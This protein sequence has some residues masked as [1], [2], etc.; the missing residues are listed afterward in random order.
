MLCSVGH[1][2]LFLAVHGEERVQVGVVGLVALHCIQCLLYNL[3][4]ARVLAMAEQALYG[5]GKG[6]VQ[7]LGEGGPWVVRQD[8]D[9]HNSI[10]LDMGAAVVLLG[11]EGAYLSRG[12]GSCVGAGDGRLDDGGE[13]KHLFALAAVSRASVMGIQHGPT[14]L[15]AA[16]SQK[17]LCCVSACVKM[18]WSKATYHSPGGIGLWRVGIWIAIPMGRLC[19]RPLAHQAAQVEALLELH[20]CQPSQ[21]S[22]SL[23]VAQTSSAGFL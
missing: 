13:M 17:S 8:S 15:A 20:G 5:I 23:L 3:R 6:L 21:A 14:E 16:D 1:Q 18:R 22:S 9:E 10:V 12:G 2:P 11:E 7:I 4:H 19:S